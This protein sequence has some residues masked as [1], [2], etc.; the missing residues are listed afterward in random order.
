MSSVSV[1]ISKVVAD[2]ARK[3]ARL[4][5]RSLTGQIEHWVRLGIQ[6]EERLTGSALR[7][8]KSRSAEGAKPEDL[9]EINALLDALA[10]P[11]RATEQALAAGV[12]A[13][14][15]GYGVD[16]EDEPVLVEHRPD[17]TCRCGRLAE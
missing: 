15:I 1:K 3:A 14:G 7:A 2:A 13:G 16:P 12:G 8:F 5:D 17:G 4:G 9:A 11:G 6:A 10:V